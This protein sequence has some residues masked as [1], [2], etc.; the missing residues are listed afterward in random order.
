MATGIAGHCL[1]VPDAYKKNERDHWYQIMPDIVW[2]EQCMLCSEYQCFDVLNK[3]T[4]VKSSFMKH[5]SSNEVTGE[6]TSVSSQDPI[7]GNKY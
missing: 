3:Q 1:V 4:H 5:L 2:Q 6:A 7:S